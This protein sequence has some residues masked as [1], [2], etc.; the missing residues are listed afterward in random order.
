[1]YERRIVFAATFPLFFARV[2][3]IVILAHLVSFKR[4][5]DNAR[6]VMMIK[7]YEVPI[8]ISPYRECMTTINF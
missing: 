2:T 3:N 4:L 6:V 8:I 1:M 5:T 7:Y